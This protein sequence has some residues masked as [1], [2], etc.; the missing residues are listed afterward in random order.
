[1]DNCRGAIG[2]EYPKEMPNCAQEEKIANIVGG[3]VLRRPA[4]NANFEGGQKH[5]I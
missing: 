4:K 1:M 3:G 5:G 2:K